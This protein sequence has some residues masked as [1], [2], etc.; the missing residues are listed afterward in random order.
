MNVLASHAVHEVTV[1]GILKEKK[2]TTVQDRL[3]T[4]V[5]DVHKTWLLG[6][7][8]L[9]YKPKQQ[10]RALQ[11]QIND[12]TKYHSLCWSCKR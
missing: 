8:G 3:D 4:Y 5:S 11:S 12:N 9:L 2:E 7:L 10:P 6:A 1:S